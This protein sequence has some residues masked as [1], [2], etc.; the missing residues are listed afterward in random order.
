VPRSSVM[1]GPTAISAISSPSGLKR[2]GVGEPESRRHKRAAPRRRPNSGQAINPAVPCP[3]H[4]GTIPCDYPCDYPP[5]IGTVRYVAQC[6]SQPAN[7]PRT[8]GNCSSTCLEVLQSTRC[9]VHVPQD[10]Q[11]PPGSLI[12]ALARGFSRK[13]AVHRC[14]PKLL[15]RG[16]ATSH[17]RRADQSEELVRGAWPSPGRAADGTAALGPSSST[18][19]TASRDACVPSASACVD[20]T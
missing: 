20:A 8:W 2:R 13:G 3:G 17:P 16:R 10:G 15:V 11:R 7:M 1:T 18:G 6:T 19:S 12:R 5:R 9:A 4:R 14:P